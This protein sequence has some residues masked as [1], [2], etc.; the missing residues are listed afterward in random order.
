MVIWDKILNMKY[1][2]LKKQ[3]ADR[4]LCFQGMMLTDGVSVTILKQNFA[5]GRRR[6]MDVVVASEE[7]GS[8]KG[9]KKQKNK[10]SR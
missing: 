3:K 10:N 9:P 7:S 2:A 1:K 6:K 4:S 5:S 8:S